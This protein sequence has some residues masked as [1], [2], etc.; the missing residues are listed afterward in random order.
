MHCH[1]LLF[2]S[3]GTIR[4]EKWAASTEARYACS[5]CQWT[6]SY[7]FSSTEGVVAVTLIYGECPESLMWLAV[8]GI[9]T[10]SLCLDAGTTNSP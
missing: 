8:H 3:L 6:C 7:Q 2:R 1:E 5:D 10:T 9:D 4:I